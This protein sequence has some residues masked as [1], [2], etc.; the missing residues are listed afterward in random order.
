[1]NYFELVEFKGIKY[2]IEKNLATVVSVADSTLCDIKIPS[3][4]FGNIKVVG[5]DN[6]AFSRQSQIT[7][8]TLPDSVEFVGKNAFAWCPSLQSIK[9]NGV[10]IVDERAFMGDAKLSVIEFSEN[11]TEIGD[12]AFAYCNSLVAIK[13]PQSVEYIGSGIFEGCR[14]LKYVSLPEMVDVIPNGTFYACSSLTEVDTSDKLRYI[15]EYAFAYC[16]ALKEISISN[17]TII[18]HDAF[19]ECGNAHAKMLVS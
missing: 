8:I 12:K 15:D 14:Y 6:K 4:I 18:N 10:K 1:M 19:Y 3:V 5:V 2:S 16:T 13:I 9:M 7:S 17:T 11:L